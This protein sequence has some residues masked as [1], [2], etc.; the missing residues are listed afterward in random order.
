M[1]L[2]AA[3]AHSPLRPL[4]GAA[5]SHRRATRLHSCARLAGTG[6]RAQSSLAAALNALPSVQSEARSVGR[7]R[8][9][10]RHGDALT[11]A[12]QRGASIG[13]LS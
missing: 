11:R 7:G 12:R 2:L 13:C 8:A 3:A 9:D 4:E 10:D 1:V 5:P 6:R